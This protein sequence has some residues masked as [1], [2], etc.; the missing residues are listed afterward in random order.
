[1]GKSKAIISMDG[2]T[3]RTAA[4]SLKNEYFY[5][6]RCDLPSIAEN[7][8]YI[9]DLVGKDVIVEDSDIKC[10]IVGAQN[11]GAGDL[12]EI[13]HDGGSFFVPFAQENFPNSKGEILI[14]RKAFEGFKN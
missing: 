11:F 12:L 6:Q 10:K 9:C 4:E 5:V 13:S 1:M 2:I 14:T 3:D 7:E 8:F